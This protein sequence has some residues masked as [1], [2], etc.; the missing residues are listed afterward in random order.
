MGDENLQEN[1]DDKDNLKSHIPD[2]GEEGFDGFNWDEE[3]QKRGSKSLL[4]ESLRKGKKLRKQDEELAALKAKT[5][6]YEA[7]E[8]TRQAQ[9]PS[10][11]PSDEDVERYK[12]DMADLGYDERFINTQ[13][14]LVDKL[15]ERKALKIADEKFK[16]NE[17]YLFSSAQES[18][19]K[20]LSERDTE[21]KDNVDSFKKE[22]KETMK[23]MFAPKFWGKEEVALVAYGIV[24]A[25]NISK[26]K[27]KGDKIPVND[28]LPGESDNAPSSSNKGE[29]T[30]S[31]KTVRDYCIKHGLEGDSPDVKKHV[32]AALAAKSRIQKAENK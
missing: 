16:D 30:I 5:E 6:E 2:E 24:M 11:K 22:I 18:A 1:Q 28:E 4:L 20:K 21:T 13:L 25:N 9:L 31:D 8:R 17:E 3:A 23:K 27:K 7:R 12:K 15:S 26:L 32:R 10:A 14:N 19:L 29:G